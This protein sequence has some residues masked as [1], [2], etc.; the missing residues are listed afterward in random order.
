MPAAV[1]NSIELLVSTAIAQ[2]PI[3][4]VVADQDH[5]ITPDVAIQNARCNVEPIPG[6]NGPQVQ[7]RSPRAD[8]GTSSNQGISSR[9]I[10][11]EASIRIPPS[12]GRT[13]S[14]GGIARFPTAGSETETRKCHC[15]Q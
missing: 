8:A 11:T 13:A 10:A 4:T 2:P 3:G 7:F 15:A 1:R 9:V 6:R 5:G 14:N 12:A